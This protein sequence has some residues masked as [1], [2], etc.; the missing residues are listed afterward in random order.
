MDRHHPRVSRETRLLLG[1]VLV[2]LAS[3]WVLARL[4]FPDQ[5]RNPN[6]VPP[7]LAQFAAPSPFEAM[8][9]AVS[10]LETKVGP[11]L[12]RV[13]FTP[14]G[15]DP[16]ARAV[17]RLAVRIDA[18]R[19][20]V[21]TPPGEAALVSSPG[22]AAVD[23]GTGLALARVPGPAIGRP[24]A[25]APLRTPSPRFLIAAEA[26]REGVSFRPVFFGAFMPVQGARWPGPVWR[27]PAATVVADGALLFT[28][29]ALFSGVLVARGGERTL[30]PLEVLAEVAKTLESLE[31]PV[32]GVPGIVV[33]ELTPLVAAA[34]GVDRGV[35]V[36]GVDP[37]G[38]AAGQLQPLDVIDGLWGQPL[39][40]TEQWDA[41]ID[42]LQAY[43]TLDLRVRR[44][45]SEPRTVTI[46]AAAPALP[47]GPAPLGVTLRLRRG[48][49]AEVVRVDA[50]GAA[51]HAGL[52][53]GDVITAIN[54]QLAPTPAQVT[55]TF[56]AA[57]EDR[58][59]AVAVRRGSTHVVLALEKT[60]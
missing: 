4:R 31:P 56:A 9:T 21:L 27:V 20:V 32:R 47:A 50:E 1:I 55:R 3:L 57:D 26:T 23:R 28:D 16:S 13:S 14:R 48:V 12:L 49:G 42:R 53:A 54:E 36:A 10:D 2:S 52:L 6:P 38:P 58:P 11:T 59:V 34:V 18:E 30:V 7:V 22:L 29:D 35:V 33:Q 60:W 46:T 45:G 17:T 44:A 41:E 15:A 51:A 40:T 8:A 24:T 43:H 19:V 39:L 25:W 5:P 37:A